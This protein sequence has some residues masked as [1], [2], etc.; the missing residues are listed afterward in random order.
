MRQKT[1][2]IISKEICTGCKVCGDLCPTGAITFTVDEEG[3]WFPV[4]DSEKC[5]S[6]GKCFHC[7]PVNQEKSK[8][9][10]IEINQGNAPLQTYA[11]WNRDDGVRR[12]STSGGLFSVFAAYVLSQ[13]GYLAGSAYTDDFKAACHI[14]AKDKTEAKKLMGSKYFQSDTA[15][16][17]K[18]T[19]ELLESGK[20]V[21]FVGTPCQVA[22]LY[23]YLK[24]RPENLITVDFI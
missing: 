13:G 8:N 19:K 11:A 20:T 22:A 2:E 12:E 23:S 16:I 4:I 14:T 6:C 3:F 10:N 21:L 1:A 24:K 9:I 15:G 17:Y 7:C 18:E 5:I